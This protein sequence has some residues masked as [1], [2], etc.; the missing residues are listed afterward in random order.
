[1]LKGLLNGMLEYKWSVLSLNKSTLHICILIQECEMILQNNYME[2][3]MFNSYVYTGQK[4]L[5]GR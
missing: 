3:S 2:Y 1:M 4:S 5:I